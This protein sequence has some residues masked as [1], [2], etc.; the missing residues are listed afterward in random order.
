MSPDNTKIV[1][2]LDS[3]LTHTDPNTLKTIAAYNFGIGYLIRNSGD[4][5][6]AFNEMKKFIMNLDKDE[7]N[8]LIW[9]W[10]TLKKDGF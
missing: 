10:K 2:S 7:N 9:W 5:K 8:D 1:R 3:E 4:W 6:G